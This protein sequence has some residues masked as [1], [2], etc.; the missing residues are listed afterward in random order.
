MPRATLYLESTVLAFPGTATSAWRA[1]VAS[2]LDRARHWF[3]LSVVLVGRS[4]LDP[5]MHAAFHDLAADRAVFGGARSNAPAFL[6]AVQLDRAD[7]PADQLWLLS[8]SLRGRLPAHARDAIEK[9]SLHARVRVL[10]ARD[11]VVTPVCA[12]DIEEVLGGFART[13]RDEH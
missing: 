9:L 8:T 1:E 11:D 10:P 4:R 5:A 6:G 7:H 12:D 3:P 2:M 13:L